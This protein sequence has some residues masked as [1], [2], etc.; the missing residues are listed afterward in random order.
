MPR[1]KYVCPQCGNEVPAERV[2]KRV[3]GT[4]G[5]AR[6]IVPI[7]C[8]AD[9]EEMQREVSIPRRREVGGD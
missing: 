6:A 8:E 3:P 9:G 2:E 4:K 1:F 7:I 5:M